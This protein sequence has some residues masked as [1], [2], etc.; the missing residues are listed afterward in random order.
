MMFLLVAAAVASSAPANSSTAPAVVRQ[1][2][3]TVRIVSGVK[4]TLDA[5]TNDGAPPARDSKITVNGT[6]QSARLIEFE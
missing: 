5:P 1:A 4:L 2:T 3:A 6:R